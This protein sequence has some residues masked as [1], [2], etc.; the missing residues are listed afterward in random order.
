MAK[1]IE[2]KKGIIEDLQAEV[3]N[4]ENKIYRQEF[5]LWKKN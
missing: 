2:E 4:A 3:Q 1:T 5:Q